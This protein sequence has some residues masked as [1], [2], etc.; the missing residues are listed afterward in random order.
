MKVR[1]NDEEIIKTA[2]HDSE[3]CFSTDLYRHVSWRWFH[4]GHTACR[5]DAEQHV[6]DADELEEVNPLDKQILKDYIDACA[7]VKE[8]KEALLKLRKAKKRREQDAV[9]GSSHEFPY[10]AQTF[11]IEGLAY[12]V[13]QDPGE[14]DRLEEI[15]RERLRK[16]ERIKHDVEAW[17]NT[18]PMRMQRIIKYKIFEGLTWNQVAIRMGRKA[19]ADGVRMEYVNFMKA[20]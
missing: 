8:T 11:H 2:W 16:A 4:G 10:T 3:L 6:R 20:A 18:I 13:L 14:E 1:W 17:L 19:T 7:Q 9:K 12:A 5:E 15:L